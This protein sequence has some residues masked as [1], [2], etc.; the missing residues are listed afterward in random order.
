MTFK[1]EIGE[2]MKKKIEILKNLQRNKALHF[3]YIRKTHNYEEE[4]KVTANH[5]VVRHKLSGRI[6]YIKRH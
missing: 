1:L 6:S 5:R 2:A 3:V 4:G